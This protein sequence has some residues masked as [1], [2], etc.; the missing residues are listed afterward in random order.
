MPEMCIVAYAFTELVC[1]TNRLG[2]TVDMFMRKILTCGH[3]LL[4]VK[5][6]TFPLFLN[7]PVSVVCAGE[8]LMTRL[9]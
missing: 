1:F 5:C 4:Y 8:E 6:C 9:K 7:K 3:E 2:K